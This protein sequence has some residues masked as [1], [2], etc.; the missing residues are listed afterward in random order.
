MDT[1][2]RRFLGLGAAATTAYFF[3]PVG[4]WYSDTIINPNNGITDVT[5]SKLNSGGTVYRGKYHEQLWENGGI[6]IVK[7]PGIAHAE[8]FGRL[9]DADGPAIRFYR[10]R[11]KM[12][13]LPERLFPMALIYDA[14]GSIRRLDKVMEQFQ[15]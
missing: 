9:I 4:G 7:Q 5:Y 15:A 8:N 6:K 3:A 2:R 13:T 11:R 12:D 10:Q 1:S 14:S